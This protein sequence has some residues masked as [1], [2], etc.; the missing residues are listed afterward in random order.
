MC[1]QAY[2]NLT[3]HFSKLQNRLNPVRIG[4]VSFHAAYSSL[5]TGMFPLAEHV[6]LH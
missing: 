2:K 3:H 1:R 5:I 6:Y 4:K